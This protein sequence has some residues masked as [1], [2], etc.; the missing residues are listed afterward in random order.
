MKFHSFRTAVWVAAFFGVTSAS[1]LAATSAQADSLKE[2]T[3]SEGIYLGWAPFY[4]ADQKKLWEKHGLDVRAVP[5]SSGRLALDAIVGG[6]AAFGTVAETP[7]VFAA[8]NGLPVR[9][10]GR[11]NTHEVFDLVANKGVKTI[12]D[13]RGK[14]IGYL[15]GS[16][17]QYYLS[18]MLDRA[19]LK[20]S[21]V[22]AISMNPPDMVNSLISGDIDGFIWAEPFISKAV[23]LG[24][25][26]VHVIRTPGLYKTYSSIVTLQSTIDNDPDVLIR[27]LRALM[28]ATKFVKTHKEEAIAI[29]AN[30]TKME[31]AIA[32]KSWADIRYGIELDPNIEK[33][34]EAQSKWAV[35]SGL[36][37]SGTK[38]PDYSKIVVRGLLEKAK[39][40]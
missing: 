33:D 13:V 24:K 5:F 40:Q 14:K 3:V 23:S 4:I 34:M 12:K 1:M 2:A 28:E 21:D 6:R 27:G 22:T 19:H 8:L 39:Q 37:R 7:V 11:V 16:N 26:K 35:A 38:I 9:I 20:P 25:G 29:S 30:K 17:A 18:L 10:I 32:K 36:V 31:P 15:Q